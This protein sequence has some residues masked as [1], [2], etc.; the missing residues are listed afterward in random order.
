[1]NAEEER[2][3]SIIKKNKAE[4]RSCNL[5][6]TLSNI[7]TMKLAYPEASTACH[8]WKLSEE[9]LQSCKKAMSTYNEKHGH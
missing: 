8:K 7:P 1:M 9:L 2:P 6:G 4:S 5:E 3:L